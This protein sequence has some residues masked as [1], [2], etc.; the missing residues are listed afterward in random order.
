[1]ESEAFISWLVINK[2]LSKRSAKDVYCRLKRI[3][4]LSNVSNIE[5][6]K[7]DDFIKSNNFLQQTMFVKSQLKRAFYLYLEYGDKK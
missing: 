6:V 4:K 2:K 3:I 1:M 5:S 7:F